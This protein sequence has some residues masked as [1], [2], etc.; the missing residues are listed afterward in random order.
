MRTASALL[1]A[2][3]ALLGVAAVARADIPVHCLYDQIV[4]TWRFDMGANNGDNSLV[5]NDDTFNPVKSL[6]LRFA[7]PNIV[8]NSSGIQVADWTMIYD[9]GISVRMMDG[10]KFTQ[11]FFAFFPYTVDPISGNVTSFCNETVL[12]TYHDA[13]YG[14]GQLPLGWGCFKGYKASYF[15]EQEA[16]NTV[17][18]VTTYAPK[19]QAASPD[20]IFHADHEYIARLNAAQNL[21]T[22]GPNPA[23]VGRP[24]REV[25]AMAGR[26]LK[27]SVEAHLPPAKLRTA[28]KASADAFAA[29]PAELN[30]RNVSGIDYVGPMRDQLSCGSCYAFSGTEMLQARIRVKSQNKLTPLLSPQR[31]VSCSAYSQGCDGGFEYLVS[32]FGQD[33][34]FVDESCFPYQSGLIPEVPCSAGCALPR[35]YTVDDF[36][37]VGGYYGNCSELGM[38]D[39]LVNYG[40]LSV[41]FLVLDSFMTYRSG[42]YTCDTTPGTVGFNP[43]E[44]VSHAV[45]LIGYGVDP[46]TNTKYWRVANSWGR[47]STDYGGDFL[48][49]RGTDECAIESAASW[50]TPSLNI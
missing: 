5:C 36:N 22:A 9:E 28:A 20:A 8:Y 7:E 26:K 4:G 37:Y 11:L 15:T 43:F 32:K 14:S 17:S 3:L 18:P 24:M 12:S 35:L 33:Y 23:L 2:L 13:P 40:P 1:V 30:W 39:H 47:H 19:P 10:A 29:Y 21:W 27:T 34:G 31:V 38:I 44:T 16:A 50:A 49:R 6:H 42:V 45:L 41:S 46:T 25:Q 48:I